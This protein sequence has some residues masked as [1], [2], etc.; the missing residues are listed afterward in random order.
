[1]QKVLHA[2]I[3]YTAK[4]HLIKVGCCVPATT[5][6]TYLNCKLNKWLGIGSVAGSSVKFTKITGSL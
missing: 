5:G 1:M 6:F 2:Y 4:K 3:I